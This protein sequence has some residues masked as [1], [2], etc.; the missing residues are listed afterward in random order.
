MR[1]S[2][3]ARSMIHRSLSFAYAVGVALGTFVIGEPAAAQMLR[4]DPKSF[5]AQLAPLVAQIAPVYA[6][7]PADPSVL[8]QVAAIYARAGRTAEAISTLRRM[9]DIGSGVH[10]RLRDGFQSLAENA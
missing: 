6:A 8:Y 4:L 10:P 7:R 1:T 5:P 3:S 9:A 2:F